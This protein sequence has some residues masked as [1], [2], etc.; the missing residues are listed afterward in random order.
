M[1][2]WPG[3]EKGPARSATRSKADASCLCGF[4]VC[5][6]EP[7]NAKLWERGAVVERIGCFG[8][9][10]GVV[11]WKFDETIGASRADLRPVRAS[12]E[13]L[14]WA[15]AGGFNSLTLPIPE[16]LVCELRWA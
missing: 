3:K 14:L 7:V 16:A 10:V 11:Q 13:N 1:C 15:Y 9:T 6:W 8:G 12:G 5:G 2:P 4:G